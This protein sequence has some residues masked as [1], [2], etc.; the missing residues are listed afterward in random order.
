MNIN[1]TSPGKAQGMGDSS[2]LAPWKDITTFLDEATQGRFV[3]LWNAVVLK[4]N[5]RT[6]FLGHVYIEMKEGE[7]IHLQS[8]TLFDAMSAIEIMDPRM[9]TGMVVEGTESKGSEYDIKQ[10]LSPSQ[11][12]W[13][14]DRLLACEVKRLSLSLCLY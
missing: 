6:N 8:F 5:E 14:M 9:D 10:V 1:D 3:L 2:F 11:V 7:L 12:L 4:T 13:I